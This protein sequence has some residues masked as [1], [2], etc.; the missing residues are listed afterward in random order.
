M[1]FQ[2]DQS[3]FLKNAWQ[4]QT[5]TTLITYVLS[6]QSFHFKT[7]IIMLQLTLPHGWILC[8]EVASDL[9]SQIYFEKYTFRFVFLWINFIF[10]LW[11][12]WYDKSTK[13]QHE[14]SQS[15]RQMEIYIINR[16]L[17]QCW[18]KEAVDSL[19]CLH[20][21]QTDNKSR[22]TTAQKQKT[23]LVLSALLYILCMLIVAVSCHIAQ[24]LP[25]SK[26]EKSLR[27]HD[28]SH[29]GIYHVDHGLNL[30]WDHVTVWS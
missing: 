9:V 28:A 29:H 14:R 26:T 27:H 30:A 17:L 24:L 6:K 13:S 15:Q 10:R 8:T 16:T 2:F 22:S 4:K 12:K 21:K 1:E 25:P 5:H 23:D 20:S 19:E 11:E 3:Q 7:D 18:K